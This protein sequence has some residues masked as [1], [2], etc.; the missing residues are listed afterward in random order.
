MRIWENAQ[1]RLEEFLLRNKGPALV[2]A[3]LFTIGIIFGALAVPSLASRDRQEMAGYLSGVVGPLLHPP[4]GAGTVLLKQALVRM[5]LTTLALW[6]LGIS[7]VGVLVV[8]GGALWLGYTGGFTVAYL[9]AELGWRGVLIAL[10]GHLPQNLLAVPALLV[11]G[12]A[13]IRFSAQVLAVLRD[14]RRMP[15]FYPELSEYTGLMLGMGAALLSAALVESYLTPLLMQVAG[16][17]LK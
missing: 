2:L 12:T 10:A 6:V 1:R 8:M 15:R 11:A 16:R 7:V 14:R 9:T 4:A 13:S 5:L 3:A 17:I